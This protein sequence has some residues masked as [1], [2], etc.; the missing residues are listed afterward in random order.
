[1]YLSTT[2]TLVYHHPTPAHPHHSKGTHDHDQ[3]GWNVLSMQWKASPET[4]WHMK[5]YGNMQC[6]CRKW[7]EMGVVH[8][9]MR[10]GRVLSRYA[11]VCSAWTGYVVTTKTHG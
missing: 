5:Q 10:T 1:M 11:K 3:G 7:M 8:Q 2:R 9:R 6:V 4:K